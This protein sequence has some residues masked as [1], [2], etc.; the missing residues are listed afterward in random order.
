MTTRHCLECTTEIPPPARSGCCESCRPPRRH[1]RP[2]RTY[3][4]EQAD[5]W[6]RQLVDQHATQ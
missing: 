1:S 2:R 6:F 3:W 5:E 4:R